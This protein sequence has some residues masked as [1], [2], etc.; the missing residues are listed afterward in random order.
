[1]YLPDFELHE[2]RTITEAAD[3]LARF[4]PDVRVL[5][6]GTDLLVDL[7]V[8]RV[9][10]RHVVSLTRLSELRG[11]REDGPSFQIGA[12]TTPNEL[13]TSPIVRERFPA[14]L[15]VLRDLAAP[16]IRNMATVG[17]NLAS[18]VPS[19]D[20]P[21]ILIS[22]H[23][24]ITLQMGTRERC[25]PLDS[26]FLGPRRTVM[27]AGEIL[28]AIRLPYPPGSS[29][30]A[31]ARFAMRQANACA[32]A[33]VAASL[34][35]GRD[36]AVAAARIVLGAVAPTPQLIEPAAASLVGRMVNE[37]SMEVAATAA[38]EAASPISDIR[39]SADYRREI[40]GVLTRRALA[41]AHRRAQGA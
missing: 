8:G 26:F 4:S 29:G 11:L 15:D 38:M 2:A 36:G 34:Q 24:A 12:L 6:G 40:V 16:Q 27:Q 13:A 23:A 35:L 19:A 21:P 31:Y 39:G 33:G 20:L 32:I 7:K 1:M 10:V 41:L 14:L 30:S 22:L 5:A 17:G 18:G 25:V 3:Y 28:T 37:D 9:K